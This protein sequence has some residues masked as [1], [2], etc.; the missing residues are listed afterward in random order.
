MGHVQQADIAVAGQPHFLPQRPHGG[1]AGAVLPGG[2][3]AQTQGVGCTF[4]TAVTGKEPAPCVS[5]FTVVILTGFHSRSVRRA[6]CGD[7][8]EHICE[9]G[10]QIY[11]PPVTSSS[12]GPRRNRCRSPS[13]MRRRSTARPCLLWLPV[14]YYGVYQSHRYRH[15]R[16]VPPAVTPPK[17]AAAEENRVVVHP[18]KRCGGTFRSEP[19][20]GTAGPP[21]IIGLHPG[22]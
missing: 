9:N 1:F 14:R 6:G 16:R 11:T 22:A 15:D 10:S 21:G 17:R 4:R 3:P 5:P 8:S 18:E 2:F 13:Q 7:S 19:A 20:P 12:T